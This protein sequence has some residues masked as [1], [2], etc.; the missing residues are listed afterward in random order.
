MCSE[1]SNFKSVIHIENSPPAKPA[2]AGF[3]AEEPADPAPGTGSDT[4]SQPQ[5]AD[6]GSNTAPE[7]PNTGSNTTLSDPDPGS[8]T[9]PLLQGPTW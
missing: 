2:H 8:N 5:L 6:T 9:T 4:P 3:L 7:L 1:L